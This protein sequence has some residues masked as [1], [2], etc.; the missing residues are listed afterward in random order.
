MREIRR[1]VIELD[2]MDIDADITML[3][4]VDEENQQPRS[5][6]NTQLLKAE[7]LTR[8][9]NG[10]IRKNSRQIADWEV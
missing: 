9:V 1:P 6:V 3:S 2:R 5:M 7:S 4:K 10:L 8:T